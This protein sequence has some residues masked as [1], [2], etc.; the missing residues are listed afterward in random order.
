MKENAIK[1]AK[2]AW[3]NITIYFLEYTNAKKIYI[4]SAADMSATEIIKIFLHIVSEPN[5]KMCLNELNQRV[6]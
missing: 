6:Y 4:I 5:F 2:N 1:F 3:E